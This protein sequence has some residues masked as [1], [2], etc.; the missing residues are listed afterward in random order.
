MEEQRSHRINHCNEF[1]DF[2]KDSLTPLT[3]RS[4]KSH[5]EFIEN[6]DRQ[7]VITKTTE[8]VSTSKQLFEVTRSE[9]TKALERI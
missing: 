3:S 4:L 9:N 8:T 2:S 1:I 5:D 7:N 6:T